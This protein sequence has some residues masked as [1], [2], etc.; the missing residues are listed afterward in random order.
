[1]QIPMTVPVIDVF[2]PAGE[3]IFMLFNKRIGRFNSLVN[4]STA[5]RV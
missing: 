2:E 4:D 5:F 1:M 3:K